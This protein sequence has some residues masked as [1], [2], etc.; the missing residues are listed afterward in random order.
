[1]QKLVRQKISEQASQNIRDDAVSKVL[2][3]ER[4]GR[5]RGLGFGALPS[6]LTGQAQSERQVHML[7]QEIQ[8]L[9]ESKLSMEQEMNELK[10]MMASMHK[11]LTKMGHGD[12]SNVS[13]I[14]FY[15]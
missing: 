5:V 3:P 9:K 10:I 8:E 11:V 12:D 7:V 14:I 4:R 1:M 6:K 2:G 13:F 15:F